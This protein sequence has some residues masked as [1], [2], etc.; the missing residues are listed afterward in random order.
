M[1]G[2]STVSAMARDRW[3]DTPTSVGPVPVVLPPITIEGYEAAY[4]KVPDLGEHTDAVL[5]ELGLGDDDIA[6]LI[7]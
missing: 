5:R 2:C 7:R 4:R 6:A 3:R 1:R